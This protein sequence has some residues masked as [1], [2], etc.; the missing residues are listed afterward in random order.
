MIFNKR[1]DIGYVFILYSLWMDG[2][3]TVSYF[4]TKKITQNQYM[5]VLLKYVALKNTSRYLSRHRT[6]L[7]YNIEYHGEA[8]DS[9]FMCHLLTI[10]PVCIINYF[11][12]ISSNNSDIAIINSLIDTLD[13]QLVKMVDKVAWFV[14]YLIE[15]Y[16]EM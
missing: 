9:A 15:N 11:I 13:Q 3:S 2:N 10:Q 6:L 8:T 5:S 1:F 12:L 7:W 4:P 14:C 16:Y